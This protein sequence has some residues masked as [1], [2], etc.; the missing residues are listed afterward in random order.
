M[1]GVNWLLEQLSSIVASSGEVVLSL[2]WQYVDN[3]I[4]SNHAWQ[5]LGLAG[6]W[7]L[8]TIPASHSSYLIL[9]LHQNGKVVCTGRNWHSK[10]QSVLGDPTVYLYGIRRI[11]ITVCPVPRQ[12]FLNLYFFFLLRSAL[13]HDRYTGN[14]AFIF[15]SVQGSLQKSE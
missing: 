8:E 13:L 15:L 7:S 12:Y 5:A 6:S 1:E 14:A 9:S 4:S 3:L 11:C 2:S 10:I